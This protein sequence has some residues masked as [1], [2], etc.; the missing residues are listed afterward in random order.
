MNM[1][2][3]D[4]LAGDI[5]A[6]SRLDLQRPDFDQAM[7]QKIATESARKERLR[8]FLN[9]LMMG[10]TSGGLMALLIVGYYSR[11]TD[12]GYQFPRDVV[13]VGWRLIQWILDNEYFL[14]PVMLI[15]GLKFII[16]R[17]APSQSIAGS[18]E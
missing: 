16:D 10:L 2:R 3:I 11:L 1:D 17:F 9:A 18:Q 6:E 15:V 12:F 8:M 5:L 14:V 4:Q 7:M 13:A